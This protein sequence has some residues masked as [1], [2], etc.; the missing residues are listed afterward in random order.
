M[1]ALAQHWALKPDL[2]KVPSILQVPSFVRSFVRIVP[3]S[4]KYRLHGIQYMLSH[5]YTIE[6]RLL[7]CFGSESAE[8][9]F[10]RRR[11]IS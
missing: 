10:E 7:S 3:P 6:L 9:E 8:F 5:E 11:N 2:Y 1:A 4:F